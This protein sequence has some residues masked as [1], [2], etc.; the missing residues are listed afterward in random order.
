MK[1]Q[2]AN[3]V[4]LIEAI[5]LSLGSY[6]PVLEEIELALQ[7]QQC[8]LSSLGDAIQKDPDLTARLLRLA[9][10]A[11]YGFASRVSTVA[12]A[13]SLIGVQQVQELISASNVLDSFEGVPGELVNTDSFWRHSLAVGIAARLISLER[14]LPN[15]DRFFVAGLLH[16]VGRLVLLL[17]APKSAQRIFEIYRSESRL[18]SE[19]ETEVLGFDHQQ[20]GG[21]LLQHWHYPNVLIQAVS[22]HHQPLRCEGAKIEACAVHVADHLISAMAVG[23]SGERFVRPLDVRAWNLLGLDSDALPR[24]VN[25]ID[26]QIDAVMSVFLKPD[27]AEVAT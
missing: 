11:F 27:A 25:G 4:K 21:L 16:D 2:P 22:N 20:I 15:P 24:I 26:D 6:A 12:E 10:S 8:S 17:Q 19:V 9:N 18:L 14:R 5:P 13:V 1:N 3:L 7:S 23:S